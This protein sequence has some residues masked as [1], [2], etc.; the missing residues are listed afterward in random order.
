MNFIRI[1]MSSLRV[2]FLTISFCIT[3]AANAVAVSFNEAQSIATD[4]FST[5]NT[6]QTLKTK[7][8]SITPTNENR[9]LYIFVDDNGSF[10][11]ISG[12]NRARKILGYGNNWNSDST[13]AAVDSL[14]T[15]YVAQINSINDSASTI[16]TAGTTEANAS[17]KILNTAQ[18]GQE[19]P[20][21]DLSP[22]GYPAGCVA[23]AMATVMKYHE[24]PECGRGFNSYEWGGQMLSCDFANTPFDW[25]NM[26]D[27]YS[28]T[29]GYT[30]IQADAVAQLLKACGISVNMYYA[31]DGSA[32]TI[33]DA[34][35]ALNKHFKYDGSCQY[36]SLNDFN[37][38]EWENLIRNEIDAGRP[39]IYSGK[40]SSG[41]GHAFVC[42]GYNSDGLF[43]F[44]WGWN[45]GC[46]GFYALSALKPLFTDYSLNG[47]MLINI[48]PTND[49]TAYA[50]L[51]TS[52]TGMGLSVDTE[53][54]EPG[55]PFNAF[56]GGISTIDD[57]TQW[58]G[59]LALA[60]VD[61][62]GAI[63]ELIRTIDLQISSFVQLS[64]EFT[65]CVA[66]KEIST[67]DRLQLL[68]RSAIWQPIRGTIVR[69]ASCPAKGNK[70]RRGKI[71]WDIHPASLVITLNQ[72]CGNTSLT[73]PLLSS[74]FEWTAAIPENTASLYY[75][76]NGTEISSPDGSYS[77]ASINGD[78]TIT[79]KAYTADELIDNYSAH[80]PVAGSL[81]SIIDSIDAKL[82]SSLILTGNIDSRDFDFMKNNMTSLS[83]VD[84]S[85]ANISSR[86]SNYARHIPANA[87]D[88]CKRLKSVI[89]P[90]NLVGIHQYAFRRTSIQSID[91][92]ESVTKIEDGAFYMAENLSLV[93]ARN[94]VPVNINSRVFFGTK[95]NTGTLFIPVGSYDQYKAQTFW[96]M[97]AKIIEDES[98]TG[99]NDIIATP[100]PVIS[101]IN[102]RLT[103]SGIGDSALCE[104]F[105]TRGALVYRAALTDNST[106]ELP[107]KTGV[108]ILKTGSSAKVIKITR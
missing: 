4:F 13:P 76:V 39:V 77:I 9:P 27:Y 102:G 95:R 86:L 79:I 103:V 57:Y 92:P 64:T 101:T 25:S 50:P 8:K 45:G 73:E 5:K 7:P 65:N 97:F 61:S 15:S 87:F 20:F 38:D 85:K 74:P 21:N 24:W 107:L 59:Q 14:L 55:V 51:I 34:A 94:P 93:T 40:S 16:W 90:E 37:I 60:L 106:L 66:T 71:T 10:V 46:N 75:A 91:L 32:A 17:E 3:I 43:H 72:S 84:L 69:P 36:L 6:V 58:E 52:T 89:L 82:I 88:G 54:I 83:S 105:D 42:D 26:L 30:E 41:A 62:V 28:E 12:D 68:A 11:I 104:I 81:S 78:Y 44:N 99:I 47:A 49:D 19:T 2:I 29:T 108:Y 63:K 22:S 98:I 35:I 31:S 96:G 80:V 100:E 23:T 56:A 1:S 33:M 48:F 53:N 18:W 67:N 70:V